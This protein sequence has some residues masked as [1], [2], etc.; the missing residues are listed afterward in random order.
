MTLSQKA[1]VLDFEEELLACKAVPC[2]F[3]WI[4]LVSKQEV[5]LMEF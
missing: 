4:I 3:D 1:Q 2:Q 5:A